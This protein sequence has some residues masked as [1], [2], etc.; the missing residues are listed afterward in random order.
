GLAERP[1]RGGRGCGRRANRRPPGRPSSPSSPPSPAARVLASLRRRSVPADRSGAIR[2][3]CEVLLTRE[4]SDAFPSVETARVHHA[5]RRR[6]GNVTA[7]ATL[8]AATGKA[9][10]W[11]SQQRDARAGHIG[12]I[13]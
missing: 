4:G 6:G 7:A 8:A 10:R 13:P 5:A 1:G 12:G 3:A 11:I 2:Y 9:G